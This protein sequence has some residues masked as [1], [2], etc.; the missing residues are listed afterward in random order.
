MK[1]D[2]YK[3]LLFEERFKFNLELL[4][5]PEENTLGW[6]LALEMTEVEL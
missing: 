1:K 5:F 4:D 3:Q 2:R 6:R